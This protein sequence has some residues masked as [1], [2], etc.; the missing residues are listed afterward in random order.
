MSGFIPPNPPIDT[1]LPGGGFDLQGVQDQENRLEGSENSDI[2]SGGNLNDILRGLEGNDTIS[3]GIGDDRIS[4]GTG[5]DELSG[6]DGADVINGGAG[7]NIITGGSGDDRLIV[8]AGGS[9][10]TGGEG[11]DVFQLNFQELAS[12]DQSSS[13]IDDL[14]IAITDITDFQPGEDRITIQGLGGTEAPIYNQDTGILSLDDV[15]IAQ[16]SAD[17]NISDEDIEIV[18]NNNPLSTVSNSEN[19]VARFLNPSIGV[20]FYSADEIEQT[21]VEENLSSIYSSEGTSYRTVD[22]TT[23]AQEVYRFF[24]PNSGVHLYTVDKVERDFLI[25]NSNGFNF[26]GVKF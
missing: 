12:N 24:N 25:E 18:N 19:T 4:G 26:E 6:G 8:E 21:Y 10:L 13:G 22:P 7:R 16:L 11:N 14:G 23:G 3:A 1:T 9:T 15:E 2:I 20:H 17:L 5:N